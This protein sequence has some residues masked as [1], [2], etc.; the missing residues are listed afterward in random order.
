L[1]WAW[2]W[3]CLC[4]RGGP[5]T[6]STYHLG[7]VCMCGRGFQLDLSFVVLVKSLRCKGK[8]AEVFRR[9]RITLEPSLSPCLPPAVCS[10]S[11]ARCMVHKRHPM[12]RRCCL[13]LSL[14]CGYRYC[15]FGRCHTSNGTFRIQHVPW[16]VY[17]NKIAEGHHRLGKHNQVHKGWIG[18]CIHFDSEAWSSESDMNAV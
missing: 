18:V 4:A 15:D 5:E 13:C 7:C 12:L 8:D 17:D 14:T 1:L 10:I 2:E 3:G 11:G 9:F 6:G 16:T